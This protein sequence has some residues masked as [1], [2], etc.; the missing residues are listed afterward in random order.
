MM[1]YRD[2][3][4]AGVMMLG[5]TTGC[6]PSTP[7]D[8]V[9]P[10]R[11]ALPATIVTRSELLSVSRELIAENNKYLIPAYRALLRAADSLKTAPR[12]SVTDKRAVPPSGDKHDYTSRAPYWWPDS[13]KA[14]GLPY[15]RRDGQINPQSRQD[16]DGVRFLAMT[17]A[18]ETLA[19][20][21]FFTRDR[22]YG[23]AASRYLRTWFIDAATR[24]NPHLRFAQAIPGV[25]DGRGIGIIDLRHFPRLLDAVRILESGGSWSGADAAAF[26]AWCNAYLTWLRE[27]ENGRQEGA[28]LNNHGTLYDA[29]VA[30]LALYVGQQ[31]LAR[32]TIDVSAKR[33]ISMQLAPDG[34]QP[35]ELER[36][37]PVHYSL[38]NLDGFTQLAEMGRHVG[39]NLWSYQAPN[40]A[41]LEKAVRFIAPYGDTARKWTKP[42]VSPV[43]PDAASIALRRAAAV[44]GD[45]ALGAA[46]IKAARTR[47]SPLRE[48]LVYPGASV[49]SLS[50]TDSLAAKGLEY[51]RTVLR[52]NAEGLDLAAGYPRVT[53]ADGRWEQRPYNQ[54]TSGFFAGTLWYMYRADKAPHWRALA[55]KWT[56]GIAPAKDIRTTHDLGFI[57]FDSFG[58]GY[59]LTGNDTYRSVVVDASTSLASRYSPKVQ[60]IKSWDTEGGTDARR[61]W[62]YPVIVD[63]LMNLE[64]LFR[65]SKWGDSQWREMAER[66]AVTSANAHVRPDGSTAHV[67]LFDPATGRLDRTVTWQ[68]VADSSSWARGQ[69]WAIHG[70]T[71][72]YRYTR[73]PRLLRAAQQTADYFLANNPADGVPYWDLVHPNIPDVERDASAGAVAASGLLDL[74]RQLSGTTGS[75]YRRAAERMLRTLSANYLTEGTSNQA[76]L[77]HSVGQ[78]PQNVEIDVGIIYADYYFVEALLRLRGLYWD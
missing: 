23:D 54:W 49:A 75:R 40:G 45:P 76:I 61:T 70:F 74:S 17:E 64:M 12:P 78:R 19:H 57:V 47:N 27:S 9:A 72:A 42:D 50:S 44:F 56:A 6:M 62:K 38:F 15:I 32:E 51:S 7:G 35:G 60:A 59:D 30:S 25:V 1:T 18:V 73:N 21:L 26:R 43:A 8:S 69:G 48:V 71:T 67:A 37:R 52:R 10:A 2:T 66:H 24:M 31:S 3:L 41:T 46:A 36:T 65:A 29:Q 28:E 39:V 22:T 77:A 34:S 11:E 55:E 58:H 14:D 20:A 68:G 13:T 16:H 5:I 63:N 33:R 4:I 53:L